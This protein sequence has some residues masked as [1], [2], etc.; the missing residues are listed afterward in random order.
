MKIITNVQISNSGGI[1]QTFSSFLGFLNKSRQKHITITG[2]DIQHRINSSFENFQK[3][4]RLFTLISAYCNFPDINKAVK[5]SDS[6][7]DIENFYTEVIEKYQQIIIQEKP[8][9]ILLNGTYFLPWCLLIASKNLHIPIILHY[10]GILTKEVAHWEE[11]SR[12]LLEQMEKSFDLKK[13][14]YVFP[15]QLAKKVVEDEVFGHKLKKFSISPNPIP[16]HFFKIKKKGNSNN[17]G[18]VSRWAQVKNPSFANKIGMYNRSQGGEFSINVVTDLKKSSKRY[19][20]L[21]GLVNLQT[22][23]S[24][25]KLGRFYNQ[26]GVVISPSLFETY[27]NVPQEALASNTPALVNSQ[28]GVAETF[29]A[30]GLQNWIVDFG[31][32]YDIY[33]KAKELIGQEVPPK[34]RKVLYDEYSPEKIHSQLLTV[35]KSV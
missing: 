9:L 21:S 33:R 8:D 28:M 20:R 7:E 11:K 26:M 13:I 32:V 22:T 12:L 10:H 6:L 25:Q 18:I 27:G 16:R 31:S 15:S 23:M 3:K 4:E 35:M 19:I 24:S 30:L 34:I 2:I 29:N 14:F 1:F 5:M 17:L